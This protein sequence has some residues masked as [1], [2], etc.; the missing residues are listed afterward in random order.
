MTLPVFPAA[1]LLPLQPEVS[2][3]VRRAFDYSELDRWMQNDDVAI[4]QTRRLERSK[5]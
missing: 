3:L 5:G 2:V 1:P 4:R